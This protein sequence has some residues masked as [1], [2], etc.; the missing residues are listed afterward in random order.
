MNKLDVRLL[1]LVVVV[2]LLLVLEV[3]L[4]A[5]EAIDVHRAD[6]PSADASDDVSILVY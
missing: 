6:V 2:A 5:P 1:G 3:L 4:D